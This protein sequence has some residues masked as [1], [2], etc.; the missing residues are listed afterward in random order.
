[1]L[2][3]VSVSHTHLLIFFVSGSD[4][5]S[6]R[7]IS[8]ASPGDETES[9]HCDVNLG[10]HVWG[11]E[12]LP[13]GRRLFFLICWLRGQGAKRTYSHCF[14][15]I[16]VSFKFLSSHHSLLFLT[17]LLQNMRQ[18]PGKRDKGFHKSLLLFGV[19]T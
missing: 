6:G 11:R 15:A 3:Y 17:T 14:I 8:E 10:F 12:R 9:I 2:V 5:S 18:A 4:L 13:H 1:M 16:R 7:G 19:E